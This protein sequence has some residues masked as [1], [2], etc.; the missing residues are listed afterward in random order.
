MQCRCISSLRHSKADILASVLTAVSILELPNASYPPPLCRCHCRLY[1][2][3]TGLYPRY[4][5]NQAL[6]AGITVPIVVAATSTGLQSPQRPLSVPMLLLFR[7]QC[8]ASHC[9]K[10]GVHPAAIIIEYQK[11]CQIPWQ[12]LVHPATIMIWVPI[13]LPPMWQ[14]LV[15][16]VAIIIWIPITLPPPW[17]VL[18]HPAAIIVWVPMM[19]PPPW[20]ALVY[21]DI[22]HK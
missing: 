7:H 12:G 5:V 2:L 13:T 8:A 19:L 6:T 1:N 20:Q 22:R 11:C 17:Q 15:H 3:A 9:W 16:P 14:V 10:V 4:F 21:P 18:V